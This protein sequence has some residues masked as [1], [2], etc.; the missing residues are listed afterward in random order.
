MLSSRLLNIRSQSKPI[1][2][3]RPFLRFGMKISI[4]KC[5]HKY[6]YESLRIWTGF[7]PESTALGLDL[8]VEF[9]V[10]HKMDVL[11]P[12]WFDH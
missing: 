5:R 12:G 4:R 10:G 6:L 7:E 3:A 1:T 11:N 8:P 9:V 2:S